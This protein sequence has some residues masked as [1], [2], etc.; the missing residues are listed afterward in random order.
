MRAL[1][2]EG[3]ELP[4]EMGHAK[5]EVFARHRFDP[6]FRKF[7]GFENFEP[8]GPFTAHSGCLSRRRVTTHGRMERES[9]HDLPADVKD[10]SRALTLQVA[11]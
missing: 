10:A 7:V 3:S 11:G 8:G 9:F 5:R 4:F 6:S 1:V 2:V